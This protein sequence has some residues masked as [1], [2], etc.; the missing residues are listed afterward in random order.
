[1]D[2]PTR[3]AAYF[4]G[5]DTRP[6]TE[7]AARDEGRRLLT[8]ALRVQGEGE[9]GVDAEALALAALLFWCRWIESPNDHDDPD[10]QTA[11]RLY[12]VLLAVDPDAEV[13]PQL[14]GPLSDPA[15]DEQLPELLHNE[16]RDLIDD[17]LRQFDD[18]AVDLGIVLGRCAVAL[19][20]SGTP[21]HAE[22]SCNLGAG[23]FARYRHHSDEKDLDEAVALFRSAAGSG[24]GQPAEQARYWAN[25]G[26]ALH[27]RFQRGAQAADLAESVHAHRR[28]LRH[29]PQESRYRSQYAAV[30]HTRFETGG[31]PR[32]LDRAIAH[33]QDSEAMGK[34]NLALMLRHRFE[35]RGSIDDLQLSVTL[36]Q[37]ILA[38][39]GPGEPDGARR[40]SALASSL[41]MR[42]T[43]L[44]DLADLDAAVDLHRSAVRTARGSDP[45]RLAYLSNLG[46]ALHDRYDERGDYADLSEAIAAYDEAGRPDDPVRA[47]NQANVLA[48]RFEHLDDIADLDRALQAY[49]AALAALAALPR[50]HI[51]RGSHLSNLGGI[52]FERFQR[53][54]DPADLA[55]SITSH[56]AAVRC[57]PPGHLDRSRRQVNLAMAVDSRHQLTGEPADLD[58]AIDLHRNA[59]RGAPPARRQHHGSGLAIALHLRFHLRGREADLAECI[60]LLR[61]AVDCRPDHPDRPRR[62]TLLAS[63][64]VTRHSETSDP[65]ALTEAVALMRD[66]VA[67]TPPRH[68]ERI[69]R[70]TMLGSTLTKTGEPALVAEAVEVLRAVADLPDVSSPRSHRLRT[71]GDALHDWWEL[72]GATPDLVAAIDAYRRAI[73][74]TGTTDPDQALNEYDLATVLAALADATGRPEHRREAVAVYRDAA[75]HPTAAV[76]IRIHAAGEWAAQALVLDEPGSAAEAFTVAV[77]LLPQ[78]AW[79]GL[80]RRDQ[81]KALTSWNT[82]ASDAAA[83][84]LSAQSPDQAVELG[85]RGRSL[86]WEQQLRLHREAHHL[87][88]RHPRLAAR[89]DRARQRLLASGR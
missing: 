42:F 21:D 80:D 13:P 50:T 45:Q 79:T 78:L 63:A 44:A 89:L 64:L 76:S 10:C 4:D 73:A 48:A 51:H 5:A 54:Q 77:D 37:E 31:R 11:Y 84:A 53:T 39:T 75:H 40:M 41:N 33:A 61:E 23:V 83:A 65:A 66:A 30:L 28:A 8:G 12:K 62:R 46:H 25:L 67:A 29:L 6:I 85:E 43:A 32:D 24:F 35:Q 52:W 38:C 74:A 14:A 49:L 57:T 47:G 19:T 55:E 15:N 60:R 9:L 70:Q 56:R 26:V 2:V 16:S 22:F 34:T 18:I 7:D 72:T 36:L 82:L 59:Y 68:V 88:A 86:M 3:L 27:T 69:G 1:M 81:E 20:P 58:E 17:S 71:L 87:A